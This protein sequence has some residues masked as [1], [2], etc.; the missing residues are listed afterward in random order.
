[1]SSS[2]RPES[3]V[4]RRARARTLGG[5][6]AAGALLSTTVLLL[7][8][9]EGMHVPGI[10]ATVVVAASGALL[11]VTLADRLGRTA[12]HALT[13]SGTVLIAACQVLARGGSPT[14]MYAMLYIWVVLH[15]ALFSSR[16]A[17][18][19]H[20]ALTTLAHAT[21][22]VWVGEVGAIAPQLALTLG[23]QV[24]AA[25]VV[26]TLAE[27]QRLLADTDSLTG[28]G[29]RRVIERTLDWSLARSRR[30]PSSPTCLA[31]MDLD[32]FKAFNDERGHVAGDRVLVQAATVW[33]GLLRS[34]DTLARTGGDEF[35]LVLHDTG[36]DEA[37]RIVERM[38]T[39]TPAGVAC[40]AGLARWDGR[41]S[42]TSLVER[43]DRALYGAKAD[44]PVVVAP[45]TPYQRTARTA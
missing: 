42:A 9:W 44:G 33:R 35:T 30:S 25:V 20:L 38:A 32:G 2:S 29:N 11:A 43:A 26:G 16:A 28:L 12:I 39:S 1:M 36:L 15:C 34:T 13:A 21:A 22:L 10:A 18:A 14:A 27:R 5:L 37:R 31:L 3:A 23:T 41:E 6:F 4:D 45:P 19:G 40:S 17:I 8:G 24:A 7:P